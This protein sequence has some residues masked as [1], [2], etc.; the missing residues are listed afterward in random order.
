[1]RCFGEGCI[2]AISLPGL[3]KGGLRVSEEGLDLCCFQGVARSRAVLVGSKCLLF[4]CELSTLSE[5]VDS[6]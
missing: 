2:L 4:A 1:M 3:L 6:S 5:D